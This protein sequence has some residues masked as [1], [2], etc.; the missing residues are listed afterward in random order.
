MLTNIFFPFWELSFFHL[1]FFCCANAFKVNSVCF[2]SFDL[3]FIILGTFGGIDVTAC[4]PILS[5]KLHSICP[6]FRSL[7]SLNL[8]FVYG[9]RDFL[10]SFSF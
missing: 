4:S 6:T 5:S 9:L 3:F 2:L 10:I 8:I 7:S 1:G